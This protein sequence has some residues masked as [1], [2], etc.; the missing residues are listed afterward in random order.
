MGI[1]VN[2]NIVW[3]QVLFKMGF[4]IRLEIQENV[5]SDLIAHI[6]MILEVIILNYKMI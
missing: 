6:H 3:I 1:A 4:V 5:N 2:F